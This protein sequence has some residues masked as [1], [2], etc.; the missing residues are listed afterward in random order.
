V[1]EHFSSRESLL[2]SRLWK[3]VVILML[4]ANPGASRNSLRLDV[5]S[6][7]SDSTEVESDPS[8]IVLSR[9]VL[10]AHD[11]S[12]KP[13]FGFSRSCSGVVGR[14]RRLFA[15]AQSTV[16]AKPANPL[17]GRRF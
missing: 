8:R 12:E 3:M 1:A 13:V 10:S 17:V 14:F 9:I 16:H 7:E 15:G 2:V 4:R 5:V 6:L 11:V